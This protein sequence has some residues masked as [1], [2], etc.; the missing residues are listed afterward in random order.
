MCIIANCNTD[1]Y[2]N[3]AVE[4]KL[5]IDAEDTPVLALELKG[6]WYGVLDFW[7]F[8]SNRDEYKEVD[9]GDFAGAPGSKQ[10]RVTKKGL[11]NGSI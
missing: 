9:K 8:M 6:R 10:Q 7:D 3:L 1:V 11:T 5:Y 4:V 2:A